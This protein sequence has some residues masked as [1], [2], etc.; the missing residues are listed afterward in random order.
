MLSPMD[1]S[2][3]S[4]LLCIRRSN[5]TLFLV[6]DQATMLGVL[7]MFLAR[8]GY[9][10]IATTSAVAALE[11]AARKVFGMLIMNLRTPESDGLELARRLTESRDALPV[12]IFADS[13]SSNVSTREMVERRW[14]FMSTPIDLQY[15]LRIVDHEWV[16]W[17]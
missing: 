1:P 13:D 5:V 2:L 17:V 12:L 6:D 4:V 10:V 16:G 3:D 15:L 11:L 14:N 7:K 8:E 9:R